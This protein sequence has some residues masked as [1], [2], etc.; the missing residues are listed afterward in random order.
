MVRDMTKGSFKTIVRSALLGLIAVCSIQAQSETHPILGQSTGVKQTVHEGLKRYIV[1]GDYLFIEVI[2]IDTTV[3][4]WQRPRQ[5]WLI[6]PATGATVWSRVGLWRCYPT[7]VECVE[8]CIACGSISLKSSDSTLNEVLTLH[9]DHLFQYILF[10]DS[11]RLP[12]CDIDDPPGPLIWEE[13]TCGDIVSSPSGRYFFQCM[14]RSRVGPLFDRNGTEISEWAYYIE[15]PD[16][17]I[18]FFSDSMLV[19]FDLFPSYHQ[20]AIFRSVHADRPSDTV[21]LTG[22]ESLP[23]EAEAKLAFPPA[24]GAAVFAAPRG[25]IQFIGPDFQIAWSVEVP[26]HNELPVFSNDG[27]FISVRNFRHGKDE[28]I[29]YRLVLLRASDGTQVGEIMLDTDC[30]R[31]R[32]CIGS[33]Y[34]TGT[35][36]RTE[37][38]TTAH[39]I[40]IDSVSGEF[41][42]RDSLPFRADIF[43]T[44]KGWVS[45]H[46]ESDTS[47]TIVTETW[48][49]R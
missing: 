26:V 49:G 43:A 48:S 19:V 1:L 24:G 41:L 8:P 4:E 16:S 44:D 45:V 10:P 32:P 22:P 47:S 11:I 30:G 39:L 20:S 2:P 13:P 23:G 27:R 7:C 18:R 14:R 15:P 5:Y 34:F 17:Y 21:Q 40:E 28:A 35:V 42:A 31:K 25:P 38:R 46:R 6:N 3:K 33:V 36:I 9:G 29:E 37:S 12:G